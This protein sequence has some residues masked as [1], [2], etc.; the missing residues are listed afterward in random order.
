MLRS[1]ILGLKMRVLKKKKKDLRRE[2]Q[3][4]NVNLISNDDGQE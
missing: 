4:I 2:R 3:H 1:G